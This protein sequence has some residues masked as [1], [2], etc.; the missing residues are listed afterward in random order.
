MGGNLTS[1]PKSSFLGG[2]QACEPV[3]L[4]LICGKSN[5]LGVKFVSGAETERRRAI[6]DPL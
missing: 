3:K 4:Q 1:P 2:Q 5:I 6:D